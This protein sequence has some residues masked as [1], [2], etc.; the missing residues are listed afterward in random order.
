MKRTGAA[1]L[2]GGVILAGKVILVGMTILAGAALFAGDALLAGGSQALSSHRPD[3]TRQQIAEGIYLFR[4]APYGEIGLDGNSIAIIGSDGV[5]VFDT[6]GTPSAASAVL[7]QIRSLTS[8]PVRYV[9]NS[10]WHWDHWYGTEIY[11]KAFPDVTVIAHEKTKMMMA[12]PAIDFNRP[13]LDQQLPAYLAQLEQRIAKAEGAAPPPANLP[14]LKQALADGRFF[15]DQKASVRHTL[16]NQ[17]FTDRLTL[18]VGDREVQ[19][20]H[21]DRAVTPGDTFLYLPKEKIVIAGD[22]LVNPVSFAL[23]S[24]P[25]GWIRTLEYIDSLDAAII[26]PG[27]GEPLRD[28]QLLK[29]TIAVFKELV[30]R[31]AEARARGLDPDAARAEILPQLKELASPITGDQPAGNRAFEIQLVDGFLHRVYDELNGP[32]TDAIAP[33]PQK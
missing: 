31:A 17:T 7:A 3:P 26:V 6:N 25:G 24:Y 33:I 14:Q 1:L 8:Q 27:H 9:V 21:R 30:K 19:V 5:L 16:P 11:T 10:H 22:L 15:L 4:T 12:G 29:A 28:E 18:T 32:L 20:L 23:S 2:A 13:G